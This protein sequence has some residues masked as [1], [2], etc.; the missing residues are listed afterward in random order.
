MRELMGG[1]LVQVRTLAGGF[2]TCWTDSHSFRAEVQK[3]AFQPYET[4]D[5]HG[6]MFL[7]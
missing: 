3:D 4:D 7:D 6:E 5:Q 1:G 2:W